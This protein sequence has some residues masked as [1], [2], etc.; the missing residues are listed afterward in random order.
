[1]LWYNHM[2]YGSWDTECDRQNYLSFWTIFCPLTPLTTP[3]TKFW[4]TEK[5]TWRYHFTQV[6]H[7]WQSYDVWFLRYQAWQTEFFCHFGLLFALLP[8]NNP[9]SQNFEKL[10]K[11]PGDITIL[12]KCTKNHDHMLYC[13]IDVTCNRFNW[14][15]FHFGL[16][17][18]LLP[19]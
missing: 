2:M 19:P 10:K 13:F 16:L 4:K 15:F 17:F 12:H 1:M 11:I 14:F 5:N 9:K 18:T 7:K 6:C 8:P 3:K